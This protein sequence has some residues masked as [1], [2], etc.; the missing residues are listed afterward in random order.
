MRILHVLPSLDPADG[1]VVAWVRDTSRILNAMGH[2][3]EAL[4]LDTPG[5]PFLAESGMTSHPVGPVVALKYTPALKRWVREHADE[6]DAVVSHCIWDYAS[7]GAFWATP[8]RRRKFFCFTHGMLD[9]WFNKAY[10]LKRLKKTLFWGWMVYPVLRDSVFTFF[11]CQEEARLA[12]LSFRPYR[13][14][15]RVVAFGTP[16]PEFD[17]EVA[18]AAFAAAVPAVAGRPFFLFL[19]RIHPKKG[20]DLL[21]RAFAE[22]CRD[23][24]H[25]LVMAGPDQVGIRPGLE[26]LAAELGVADRVLWPGLLQGDAKWGAY[27]G[28][29][30]FV[31]PSHQENFGL[32]VAE[33]MAVGRPVLISDKVNIHREVAESGGGL[34]EAD[35]Q[36]GTTA[37][38]TRFLALGPAER[39]AL[40]TRA[41]SGFEERFEATRSAE[42]FLAAV[43]EGLAMARAGTL[44]PSV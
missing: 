12:R 6:Y 11:T 10:P 43:E 33:A 17:P 35:T 42:D 1:G 15:E 20:C 3:S 24:D 7:I 44:G 4:T 32:V 28:C 18:R 40:S 16:R 9:P 26:A 14:R 22:A 23:T 2:Q 31:L 8:D 13:V 19:S 25:L 38:L 27:L 37:L 41:Q 29:E 21:V 5:A 36:E 30:A 34:V 39:A